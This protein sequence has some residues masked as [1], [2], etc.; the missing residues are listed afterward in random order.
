MTLCMASFVRIECVFHLYALSFCYGLWLDLLR[1]V[2]F[3]C[4]PVCL[5]FCLCLV[6]LW[7]GCVSLVYA[8]SF[9][10]GFV[11]CFASNWVCFAC[12]HGA[13]A[14]DLCFVLLL[15]YTPSRRMIFSVLETLHKQEKLGSCKFK[16]NSP[17]EFLRFVTVRV[18]VLVIWDTNLFCVGCGASFSLFFA[19]NVRSWSNSGECPRITQAKFLLIRYLLEFVL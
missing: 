12:V 19:W 14:S 6:L 9:C 17:F 2:Y 4:V 8:L 15:V 5:S 3:A 13:F 11:S 16:V 18:C 7:I 1:I 10:F